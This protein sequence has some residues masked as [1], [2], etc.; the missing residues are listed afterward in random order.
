MSPEYVQELLDNFD[1]M[2]NRYPGDIET[3]SDDY[4]LLDAGYNAIANSPVDQD[5][6]LWKPQA[7]QIST[8]PG[9]VAPY[10]VVYNAN[11][12][13]ETLNAGTGSLDPQTVNE[14]KGSA[15]FFRAYAHFQ[16]AQSFAKPY[17]QSTSNQDPGI[18]IRTSTALEVKSERGTVQQTYDKIIADFQDALTSL[19]VTSTIKSRPNK[20]ACYAALARTYLSMG[21]YTNAG[22]MADAC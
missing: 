19:P 12:A 17:D 8:A 22:K 9:W 20:T 10:G 6:Y 3:C 5:F 4:F 1:V 13:L 7:Q 16:V 15:L 11:L 2:N 14:L 18:P 21:D